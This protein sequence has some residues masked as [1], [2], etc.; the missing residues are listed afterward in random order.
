MGAV[1]HF[2]IFIVNYTWGKKRTFMCLF[3]VWNLGFTILELL[4]GQPTGQK[5]RHRKKCPA[6]HAARTRKCIWLAWHR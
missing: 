5:P 1:S 4:M 6:A 3:N 2:V